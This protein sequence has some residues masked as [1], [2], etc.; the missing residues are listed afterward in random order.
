MIYLSDPI[1]IERNFINEGSVGS[2]IPFRI[3]IR[4]SGAN[5]YSKSNYSYTQIYT[6]HIYV[7]GED[8]KIY[9]NDIIESQLSNHSCFIPNLSLTPSTYTSDVSVR[10]V[11]KTNYDDSYKIVDIRFQC[12]GYTEEI[13]VIVQYQKDVNT[14][15]GQ[16]INPNTTT[17]IIYNLLNQRTNI[18]PRIPRLSFITNKFWVGATVSMSK[19]FWNESQSEGDPVYRWI[20]IISTTP[21]IDSLDPNLGQRFSNSVLFDAKNTTF[22]Q[23]ITGEDLKTLTSKYYNSNQIGICGI[24][25]DDMG[26]IISSITYTRVAIVDDCP[27]KYYLIW[28]DRTG[29]YQC[30]PFSKKSSNSEN[31]SNSN[32]MNNIDEVRPYQKSIENQ[33]TINSDWL[34]YDEYKAYESIFTSPYLYLYDTEL[35]EGYWVNTS[36]INWM[37]KSKNNTKKPFNLQLTLKSNKIQNIIY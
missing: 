16:L 27:S 14:E 29:A 11:T 13:P 5:P 35:D 19:G 30:Q 15:R 31:I 37:E 4:H 23:N 21:Q 22:S 10:G 6:G 12:G 2:S 20:G 1:Y 8:Q 3:S 26:E 24:K 33:W 28:M 36:D 17:P 7:S 32:L 34:T 9:L 25:Y 18:I